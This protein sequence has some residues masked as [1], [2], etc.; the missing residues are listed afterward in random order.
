MPNSNYLVGIDIGT[1]NIK[2]LI[3]GK[4][5]KGEDLEAVFQLQQESRGVRRGIVISP[6][7]VSDLLEEVVSRAM[8]ETGYRIG[9]AYINVDGSHL[10]GQS[11]K[12]LISVSR[13]DQ[14]ISE[15]DVQRVLQA[16]QT[17][18]L[19][20]NK[21]IFD[22]IPRDFS[23]DGQSGIKDAVG[24][25]GMRLEAEVLVLG[26]FAPYLE[27][28]NQAVLNSEIQIS[29]RI[30][31]PIAASRA[32]LTQKQ[33]ELGTALVDVGAGTTGL[34]VFEEG[35]LVHFAVLPVGSAHIT[36]DLAIGLK[37]DVE[38][39]EK[40]KVEYGACLPGKSRKSEKIEI[41]DGEYLTFSQKQLADIINPRMTEVFNEINKELKK[42]S[43]EKKLPAGIVLAGGGV[44]LPR[45]VDLAKKQLKLPVR[46]GNPQGISSLKDPAWS[47]CCGLVLS[48]ADQ[49]GI[50]EDS[51]LM[52]SMK[53]LGS[54]LKK[55]LRAFL[56]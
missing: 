47:T 5:K 11:S 9:S 54:K 36:N 1:Q 41:A 38:I 45:I 29:D 4:G 44:K 18:S 19:P 46:I 49:E 39:A 30:P 27:N 12:G 3:V 53:G 31:S 37:C 28:L 22:T 20:P 23:V 13:A 8:Q 50:P 7:E 55:A 33:K 14:K 34:A 26:G 17:F 51:V 42:I 2:T 35:D 24:L 43:R 21:E 10:F 48:G 25:K 56:P 6:E 32:C 40:I 15:E 16:A 52:G